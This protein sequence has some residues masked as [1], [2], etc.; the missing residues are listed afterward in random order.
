MPSQKRPGN[1]LTANAT[2]ALIQSLCQQFNFHDAAATDNA[3]ADVWKRW[4]ETRDIEDR[5]ALI[6]HY[7]PMVKI[8]GVVAGRKRRKIFERFDEALSDGL[9]ML[10]EVIHWTEFFIPGQMFFRL[11]QYI[12]RAFWRGCASRTWAGIGRT[13]AGNAVQKVRSAL[14]LQLGRLP[15]RPEMEAKLRSQ[16]SNP[17]LYYFRFID[18]PLRDTV[19]FTDFAR[20]DGSRD[21]RPLEFTDQSAADP[22]AAME[23]KEF[24]RVAMK[25]MKP[26]DKK[27]LRMALDGHTLDKIGKKF[28]FSRQRAAQLLNAA[29]WNARERGRLAAYMDDPQAQPMEKPAS[30]YVAPVNKWAAMPRD[31]KLLAG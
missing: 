24:F 15:T 13:E 10:T 17:N 25:G 20:D 28:G 7:T 4:L 1:L 18:A 12:R 9:V 6:A 5:N 16:F 11:R 3:V 29:I 19:T 27:I 23:H 14:T 30:K 31:R 21:A 2:P 22:A 8:L 26:R